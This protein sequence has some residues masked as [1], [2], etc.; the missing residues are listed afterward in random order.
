L[1][2]KYCSSRKYANDGYCDVECNHKVCEY[3]GGD[4]TRI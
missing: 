2:H 1:C 4:C 3:D